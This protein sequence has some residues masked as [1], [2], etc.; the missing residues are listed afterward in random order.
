MQKGGQRHVRLNLG[1]I[2]AELL[3]F[4]RKEYPFSTNVGMNE[5]WLTADFSNAEFE[6]AIIK[7]LFGLLSKHYTPFMHGTF[8]EHC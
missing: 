2:S 6:G 8:K 1:S 7:Y 5:L 3:R 4:T